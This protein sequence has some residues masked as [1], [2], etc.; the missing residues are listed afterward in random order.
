MSQLVHNFNFL[1]EVLDCLLRQ[2]PLSK[3]LNSYFGPKPFALVDISVASTPN[4]VVLNVKTDFLELDEKVKAARFKALY[5]S[6]LVKVFI[7]I[8]PTLIVCISSL[9]LVR[10]A[11]SLL[12]FKV[13]HRLLLVGS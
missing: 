10:V 1:N 2:V 4:E 13:S 9:V 6:K 11:S 12:L 5:Q 8:I 3:S 7:F